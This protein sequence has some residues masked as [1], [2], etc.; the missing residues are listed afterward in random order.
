MCALEQGID[1]DVAVALSHAECSAR[2]A[3]GQ[4][5]GRPSTIERGGQQIVERTV[6]Q[7]AR[8]VTGNVYAG[9]DGTLTDSRVRDFFG[10]FVLGVG[11][12]V[13]PVTRRVCQP[14]LGVTPGV[15]SLTMWVVTLA[16][17]DMACSY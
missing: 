4:F 16:P 10:L 5:I 13:L 3:H 17:L 6:R 9:G 8:D 2:F 11:V 12:K 7:L 1:T 15:A 14:E